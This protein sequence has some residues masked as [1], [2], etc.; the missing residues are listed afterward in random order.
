[1]NV[2]TKLGSFETAINDGINI[3]VRDVL[4]AKGI[5]PPTNLDA[6]YT[7]EVVRLKR[8]IVTR[9]AIG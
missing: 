1:M 5:I 9:L 8:E 2:N 4:V 3:F 6:L 7:L